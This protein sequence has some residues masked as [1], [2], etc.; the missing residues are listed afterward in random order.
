MAPPTN[1]N[2][3]TNMTVMNDHD[4]SRDLNLKPLPANDKIS[5]DQM[6]IADF[7][8]H[9]NIFITGG[10]GF[11]GTVLIEAL[12]DA[13]PDIGTIYVLVR[14]KKNLDPN[15]R[16]KRLLQKPVSLILK[17]K[18]ISRFSFQLNFI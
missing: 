15:D 2:Y 8:A 10:T 11:L 13:T 7:F 9:K 14:G 3:T 12:L 6:T 1:I 18:K 4:R 17:R 5:N 16:I